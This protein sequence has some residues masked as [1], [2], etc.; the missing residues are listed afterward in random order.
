MAIYRIYKEPIFEH[1]KSILDFSLESRGQQVNP[2][3][4]LALNLNIILS[5]ACLV[6]SY[7][8]KYGKCILG[9]YR[10]IYNELSIPDLEFRKP[11]NMF[12]RRIETDLYTRIAQCT[13]ID[14]FDHIFELLTGKSLKQSDALKPLLEP[15]KVLF[16]LRNVIA[17]G[18]EVSAYEV[19]AYWNGNEFEQYFSGGYKRAEEFLLK[20]KIID[21]G[22][23]E[24]GGI[25]QLFSNPVADYFFNISQQFIAELGNFVEQNIET[26]KKLNAILDQYNREHKASYSFADFCEMNSSSIS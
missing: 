2:K 21:R 3:S 1:Y 26:G 20:N 12:Y 23:I 17:H 9:Y 22:F 5:S 6:E 11:M 10:V 24:S 15:V 14:N 7:L 8:E 4:I 25:E 18:R 19:S 16:Q 13:G